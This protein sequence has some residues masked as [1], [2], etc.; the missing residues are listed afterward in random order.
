MKTVL[1]ALKVILFSIVGLIAAMVVIFLLLPKGH[2]QLMKFDD[3]Y[4]VARKSVAG[5]EYMAS[6]GSPWRMTR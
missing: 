2:G 3:P 5:R 6:T 1:K 4:H